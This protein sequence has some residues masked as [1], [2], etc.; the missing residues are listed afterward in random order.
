MAGP[1]GIEDVTGAGLLA[2]AH[3]ARRLP[4]E[5]W[6]SPPAREVKLTPLRM[7]PML[8]A[9]VLTPVSAIHNRERVNPP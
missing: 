4:S 6:S 2:P 1:G 3:G 7:V 9:S 8:A 5:A